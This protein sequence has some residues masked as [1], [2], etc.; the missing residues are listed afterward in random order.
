M[1]MST[2]SVLTDLMF[3]I[4]TLM[5]TWLGTQFTV[6]EN[7]VSQPSWDLKLLKPKMFLENHL[8][9]SHGVQTINV[10]VRDDP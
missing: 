6:G 9:G 8:R 7:P 3:A 2:N 1:A 4:I 10:L 5:K